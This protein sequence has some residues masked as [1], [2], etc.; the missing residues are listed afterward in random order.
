[1]NRGWDNTPPETIEICDSDDERGTQVTIDL[2]SYPATRVTET[3]SVPHNNEVTQDPGRASSA[4]EQFSVFQ[5]V[6][7]TETEEVQAV[8][9]TKIRVVPDPITQL[10]EGYPEVK[11][12]PAQKP[13]KRKKVKNI[14]LSDAERE[15]CL[16]RLKNGHK[17]LSSKEDDENGVYCERLEQVST[18]C[19]KSKKPPPF[20][21]I[22]D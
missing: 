22:S 7:P 18:S 20:E 1:M 3:I 13:K 9:L 10:D 15:A 8:A 4:T 17:E 21:F 6:A 19:A 11:I 5:D 12:D 2:T 16:Q 14:E